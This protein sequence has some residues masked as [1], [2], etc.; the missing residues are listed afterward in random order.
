MLLAKSEKGYKNLIKL[1]STAF[2]DGFYYKPRVDK[3][4]LAV[5]SEG[6]IALTGCLGGE[7]P[8]HILKNDMEQAERS[9]RDYMDIFGR[10]DLYI[11]LQEHFLSEQRA[12]NQALIGLSERAGLKLVCTNDIHYTNREDA[13]SHDVLLC[14]QTGSTLDDPNRLRFGTK[15]FYMKSAQEM[16]ELFKDAPGALEN[17]LEI[18]ERC[19]CEFDFGRSKLPDPGV[20]AGVRP[21]LHV[22]RGMERSQGPAWL[23]AA[24]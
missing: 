14:I 8:H 11:E 1:V 15:E 13:A 18:A 7:V 20:P 6:L 22:F 17:T 12:V 19:N 9:L 21:G 16:A 5:Y 24:R 2:S 3:E 23:R 10:D 4:L